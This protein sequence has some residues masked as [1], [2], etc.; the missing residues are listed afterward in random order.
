MRKY[1]N[2]NVNGPLYLPMY[3]NEMNLFETLLHPDQEEKELGER[4]LVAKAANILQVGEFQILQLAYQD[5]YGYQMPDPMEMN[6]FR[7]YMLRNDV[8]HWARHYARKILFQYSRGQIDD[9][10]PSYHVYDSEYQPGAQNGTRNFWS[11]VV[12]LTLGIGGALALADLSISSP[13]TQF[14]PYLETTD[15]KQPDQRPSF[16]RADSGI[17][18]PSKTR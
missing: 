4:A 18:Q 17:E 13:A 5:W 10:K 15:L 9:S 3:N 7:S 11:A 1:S 16:G 14:P 12:M 8:P 6:L 2:R